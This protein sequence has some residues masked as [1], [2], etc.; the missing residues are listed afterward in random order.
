MSTI[1]DRARQAATLAGAAAQ[2]AATAWVVSTGESGAFS[3]AAAGGDPPI[4]PAGYAF[5]IWGPIYAGSLGYAI[6][7]AWP[8]RTTDPAFRRGGWGAAVAFVATAT[9]LLV[10]VAPSL[11]PV[12]VPVFAVIGAGLLVARRALRDAPLASR[13]DRWLVRAPIS[14]FLGW[15][16]VAIFANTATVLRGLGLTRAGAETALCVG[17]LAAATGTA[18]AITRWTRGD[19]WY[20]GTVLWALAGIVVAN[21]TGGRGAGDPVVAAVALAGALVVGGAWWPARRRAASTMPG[22]GGGLG[23]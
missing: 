19:G 3:D 6:V 7:Q 9:W 12:T 21:V 23:A 5:A 15:T 11:V 22:G 14:V 10:A 18:A 16:S 1:A 13:R 17:L 4:V 2:V 20:A 8:G